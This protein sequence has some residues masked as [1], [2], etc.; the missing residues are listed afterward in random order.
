MDA[1]IYNSIAII[2]GAYQNPLTPATKEV[3]ADVTRG[4]VRVNR[5][6]RHVSQTGRDNTIPCDTGLAVSYKPVPPSVLIGIPT[7][8]PA[9]GISESLQVG[10]KR[11]TTSTDKVRKAQKLD[12]VVDGKFAK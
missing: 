3:V 1:K 2:V 7:I 11:K 6:P 9:C 10:K 5:N 12:T 8:Y 4:S